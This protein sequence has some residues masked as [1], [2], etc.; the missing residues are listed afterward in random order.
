MVLSLR[1]GQIIDRQKILHKLVE[2]Q[3]N[4]NGY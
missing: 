4:R 2:I 1:L 3:Y